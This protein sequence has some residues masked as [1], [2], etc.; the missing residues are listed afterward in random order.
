VWWGS[1]QARVE[2]FA[3]GAEGWQ[4]VLADLERVLLRE[5]VGAGVVVE[6]QVVPHDAPDARS[7]RTLVRPDQF[8]LDCTGRTGLLARKHDVR[9]YDDGPKT[10]ALAGEWR[11]E[12]WPLP[13]ESHTLVESY[14]DGWMWSVP[15][16]PGLRHVSAMIDPQR[17]DLARGGPA[18]DIYLAEIAKT[19]AFARLL[20]GASLAAGPSGWD[21]SIYDAVQYAGDGWL[22]VGDA[23]S[24]IDPLSS[25]GVKKALASAWLAAVTVNTC[26]NSSA[27]RSHALRFFDA[28]ERE[29]EQHHRAESAAFLSG[30]GSHD[31]PFWAE[32]IDERPALS[33]AAEVRAAHEQIRQASA[34]RFKV[35]PA[36]RIEPAPM[37]E[38]R[39]IVLA[40]HVVTPR[41]APVRYLYG[42]DLVA[43]FEVAPTAT[44]VPDLLD[45]Y[46]RR[47]SPPPLHDFLLAL[48]T[49]VARGWLVSQ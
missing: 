33:D 30:A 17:S 10:I 14:A 22:L 32:R 20:A 41:A 9:R 12:S 34:I 11:C 25:A 42:T 15:T 8:V 47:T 38:G 26:V 27:M 6:R 5:A 48:S 13:D 1:E 16:A 7:G 49:A 24:F 46:A 2:P 35:S 3:D 40:P 18:R 39:E 44:Q 45:A 36:V 43:L 29:I 28:R 37:V 23:G 21:A 4:V 19:R 31:R